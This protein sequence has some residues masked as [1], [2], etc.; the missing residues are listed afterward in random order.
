MT[1][2][3]A[4]STMYAQQDRF[5]DGATFARYVADAGYDSIEI[6]HSTRPGKFPARPCLSLM[7]DV[8]K[9]HEF[10]ASRHS[11]AWPA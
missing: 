9:N 2:P 6:S 3:L 1:R 5:E 7:P 11:S 10:T 8:F 4:L